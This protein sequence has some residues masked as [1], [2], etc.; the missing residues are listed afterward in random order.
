M[1]IAAIFMLVG[2]AVVVI[3]GIVLGYSLLHG[4]TAST[5]ALDVSTI[6]ASAQSLYANS[7]DYSGIS[8]DEASVIPT[9]MQVNGTYPT[10]VGGD[11][12][13]SSSAAGSPSEFEVEMNSLSITPKECERIITQVPSVSTYVNGAAVS[14][15]AVGAA[16]TPT[17]ATAACGT[18]TVTSLGFVHNSNQ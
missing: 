4:S 16:P 14:G 7:G 17:Q 6:A 13:L 18:G 10:P 3:G 11:W 2:F 1:P 9:N 15:Q 5:V 12:A 8:G